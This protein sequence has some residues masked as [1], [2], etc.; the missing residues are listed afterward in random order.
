MNTTTIKVLED[1]L[2]QDQESI[3]KFCNHELSSDDL[4]EIQR[5]DFEMVKDIIEKEGFPYINISSQDAYNG[6]FLSIL[7]SDSIKFMEC[8]IKLFKKAEKNQIIKKHL[9]F[10]IDKRSVMM[11]EP[12]IYGTQYDQSNGGN[13][14]FPIVDYKNLNARRKEMGLEEI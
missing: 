11:G 14:F 6:A 10:L 2:K 9:A 4:I 8:V 3:R 5:R 13:K 1:I 12:Q 7:H